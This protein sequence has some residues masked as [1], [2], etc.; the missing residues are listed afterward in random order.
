MI[1]SRTIPEHLEGCSPVGISPINVM[2]E[3][4][5]CIGWP[6]GN[7]MAKTR[8]RWHLHK[9]CIATGVES[10]LFRVLLID[11][12]RAQWWL[13]ST[14]K[15]LSPQKKVFYK[16][17]LPLLKNLALA[18][19]RTERNSAEGDEEVFSHQSFSSVKLP[20][21]LKALWIKV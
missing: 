10:K 6:W 3:Y 12:A 13:N 18:F 19:N 21:K 11:K 4:I 16:F 2:D 20:P 9:L 17:P 8:T 7:A 15:N 1:P 5:Y 14:F